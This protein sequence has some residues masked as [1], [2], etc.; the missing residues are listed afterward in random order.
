MRKIISK[1]D[2]DFHSLLTN[3]A[4]EIQKINHLWAK[5]KDSGFII[6]NSIDVEFDKKDNHYSFLAPCICY[7]I[8]T[9]KEEVESE[10]Y[11]RLVN[12]I[13]LNEDLSKT[14]PLGG[15]SFLQLVLADRQLQLDKYTKELII[16]QIKNSFSSKN[17]NSSMA[18]YPEIGNSSNNAVS[19]TSGDFEVT[20]S[21]DAISLFSG[22]SYSLTSAINNDYMVLNRFFMSPCFDE[23][24]KSKLVSW[25]YSCY[26]VMNK[27]VK[28]LVCRIESGLGTEEDQDILN[29][30]MEAD[31][32]YIIG[33]RSRIK[34]S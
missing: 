6:A 30:L 27:Y 7:M 9:H 31:R 11:N 28:F 25:L 10:I 2:Y 13:I 5:I 29:R 26:A 17:S 15:I 33:I 18:V 19:Y 8:L 20:I 14:Q 3:G 34:E 12:R 22:Q 21:L 16:K 4:V 32:D 24:T 1:V 23:D